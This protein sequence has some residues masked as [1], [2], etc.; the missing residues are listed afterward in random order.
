MVAK[1]LE[2]L[3]TKYPKYRGLKGQPLPPPPQKINEW[4]KSNDQLDDEIIQKSEL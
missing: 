1:S 4:I 3:E 2:E